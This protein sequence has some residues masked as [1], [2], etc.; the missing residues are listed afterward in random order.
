[1][2]QESERLAIMVK[3]MLPI[4]R[5]CIR[6]RITIQYVLEALK[7]AFVEQAVTELN[8]I[9]EKTTLSRLSIITGVDRPSVK[10]ITQG[11]RV[12]NVDIPVVSK[13]IGQWQHNAHFTTKKGQPKELTIGS[14]D[15]EFANLIRSVTKNYSPGTIL[16]ELLKQKVVTLKN[17]RISLHE[18]TTEYRFDEDRLLHLYARNADSLSSAFEENLSN[19][20]ED[21]NIHLR[22]EYDNIFVESIPEIRSWIMKEA[23][24]FHKKVRDFLVSHDADLSPREGK[25]GGARV[26]L[27]SFSITSIDEDGNSKK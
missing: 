17:N 19:A 12:S 6:M 3:L 11:T 15:S 21:R 23:G 26:V 10:K 25:R 1:M 18:V 27:G 8:R 7:I 20:G 22:T 13:V 9:G 24:E 14:D 4:A 16:Q 5:I 2:A